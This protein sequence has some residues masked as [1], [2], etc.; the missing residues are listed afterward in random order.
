MKIE[1]DGTTLV[2]H[3]ATTNKGSDD[4]VALVVFNTL[5]FL[6]GGVRSYNAVLRL[7]IR[8]MF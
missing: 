3:S 7:Y 6:F 5:M 8:K 4:I 2:P 1:S